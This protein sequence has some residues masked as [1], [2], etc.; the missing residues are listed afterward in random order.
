MRFLLHIGMCIGKEFLNHLNFLVVILIVCKATNL[1]F[2]Q[3][4]PFLHLWPVQ[5]NTIISLYCSI[6][7]VPCIK[8][9][10]RRCTRYKPAT[11]SYLCSKHTVNTCNGSNF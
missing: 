8:A 5:V 3:A 11:G 1:V 10:Y 9:Y 6:F 2:V 7:P 4:D